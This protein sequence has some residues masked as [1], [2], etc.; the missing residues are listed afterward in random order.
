MTV[1]HAYLAAAVTVLRFVSV[2]SLGS[3]SS[4]FPA[5]A[6]ALVFT[7][8]LCVTWQQLVCLTALSLI[9]SHREMGSF[10]AILL[11]NKWKLSHRLAFPLFVLNKTR[12]RSF[13]SFVWRL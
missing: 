6:H 1:V 10:Q 12:Q 4:G 11:P 9:S 3:V 7:Q 2:P 8:N 5:R 13:S